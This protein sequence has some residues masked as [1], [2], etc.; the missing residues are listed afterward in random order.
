[1]EKLTAL[2]TIFANGLL[3][4]G[5]GSYSKIESLSS[6]EFISSLLPR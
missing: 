1:M 2:P 5:N 6:A 4:S 3:N